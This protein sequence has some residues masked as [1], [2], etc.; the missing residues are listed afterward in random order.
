M[1]CKDRD[2]R[3]E[4]WRNV[5]DFQTHLGGKLRP[6]MGSFQWFLV[7]SAVTGECK[8]QCSR[9]REVGVACF[10]CRPGDRA[11]RG[12]G[13]GRRA[14]ASLGGGDGACVWG[15]G[16]TLGA[17]PGSRGAQRA[18]SFCRLVW[19]GAAGTGL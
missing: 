4:R 18:Q 15:A 11:G 17:S 13:R 19:S 3:G 8:S 16:D 1:S 7:A 14:A 2:L 9:V 6:Q 10:R 12:T 5:G